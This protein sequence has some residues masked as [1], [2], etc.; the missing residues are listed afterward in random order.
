MNQEK[1]LVDQLLKSFRMTL[2]NIKIYPVSS[3][4]VEKQINELFSV[5][6][7]VLQEETILTISEVDNKIF[8]ND[9]EY[10]GKDPVSIANITP[11]VQFFLQSGIKSITFKKE[12]DLEELKTI[13]L[14]LSI[15]KPKISTKDFI[16]QVIKEK[17]IKNIAIDEV[18]YITITKSD[19]SVKS[20]LNLISQPVSDLPELINLLGTS[21][22]E[23]DKIKDEKTKKN[24]TDA[25]I[26][27]VS[28]LDINLIKELFI[29][30]LPQKIEETG[31]KQQLFNNLTKQNVEEI[32]NEII[33]WCKQ[34]KN[35]VKSETEYIEQLQNMKEFIKLVVNSPVS[36]LVPIEV[37]EELFKIGLIDALPE[38]ILQQKEEKKSWIAQLEELLSTNEPAKLLQEKFITNLQENIEKLCI[39]GLDDKLDKL[40]YLMTENFS[41]PV[42]KL[43]QLASSAIENIAKQ[44]NKFQK[45]KI[46]KN[47]VGNILKFIIKEQDDTI[48][49]LQINTLEHSLACLIIT[50]DYESFVEYAQQLLRFAEELSKVNSEKS[51]LIYSLID[52]VYQQTEEFILQDLVEPKSSLDKIVWILTYIAEQG[53]DTILKAIMNTNKQQIVNVLLHI[54]LSLKDQKQVIESVEELIVPQTP[55]HKLSKILEILPKLNYDFSRSLKKIY[56]YTNYANKIAILNYIQDNPTEEN[57]L[58]LTSLLQTEEPQVLEYVVDIITSLEYKPAAEKIIKL[59]KTKDVDLKKRVCISIGMLKYPDGIK[60]LKKIVKSKKEPID[61]RIAACWSLGNFITLPEVKS[62]FQNLAKKIKEPAIINVIQEVLKK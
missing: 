7:Q 30:P 50:D 22:N 20:I 58:W 16:L 3:P 8:I 26:K 57:L 31:F 47:L 38:W 5:L 33:T 25:I 32:F 27:Y 46:A 15:K 54:L 41:N 37:F 18:E 61:L 60:Q 53:I 21:F 14:A 35:S 17:N 40:V 6:K 2:V 39:I 24:L 11:I 43:R 13:L 36:K 62:F 9:K 10:I 56:N 4:L 44:L 29:Q 1:N 12:I 49:K 23:L 52:K 45:G 19:Q 51:K 34:L 28:S 48:V 55:V 42:V 59:L